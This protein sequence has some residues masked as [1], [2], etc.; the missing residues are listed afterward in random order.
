MAQNVSLIKL[1][2]FAE[3]DIFAKGRKAI[4]KT[5]DIRR[6]G[7]NKGILLHINGTEPRSAL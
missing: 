2:P 3:I 7:T 4:L 5:G 1:I 6:G